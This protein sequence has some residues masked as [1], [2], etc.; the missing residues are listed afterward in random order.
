MI[1]A[2]RLFGVRGPGT[3]PGD[4]SMARSARRLLALSPMRLWPRCYTIGAWGW[5]PWCWLPRGK[6]VGSHD[7]FFHWGRRMLVLSWCR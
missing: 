4:R 7:L 6:W 5:T 1:P 3:A 2:L